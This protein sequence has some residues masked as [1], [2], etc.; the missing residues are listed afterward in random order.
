MPGRR[1]AD[2]RSGD[3]AEGLALELLRAIA[4]VAPVPRP[5]DVG[6]DAVA[7][8]FRRENGI[9]QAERTFLV[10]VKAASARQV[11][12]SGAEADWFRKLELPLYFLKVEMSTCTSNLYCPCRATRHSNFSDQKEISLVFSD[13][14]ATLC[15][16]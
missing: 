8:I 1:H 12:Y 11:R 16:Q 3:R 6:V 5:E 7:T 15:G 9:L 14:P 2:F 10:Q 13:A 4:F